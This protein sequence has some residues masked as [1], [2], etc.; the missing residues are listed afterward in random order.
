MLEMVSGKT[1]RR[2]S[3]NICA[4][5]LKLPESRIVANL[6]LQGVG[7]DAWHHAM[8]EE[9]VLQARNPV[10][11]LRI[12]RLVRHVNLLELLVEYLRGRNLLDRVHQSMILFAAG[13]GGEGMIPKIVHSRSQLKCRPKDSASTGGVTGLFW[14]SDDD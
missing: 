6:L 14:Q 10:S 5:S 8:V 1:T 4:G 9:N 2:Y 11:A 7:P 3:A 12:G 13:R